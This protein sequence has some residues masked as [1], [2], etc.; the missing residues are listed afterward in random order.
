MRTPHTSSE[1]LVRWIVDA[2]GES[3]GDERDRL[4]YYEAHSA[5]TTA[6]IYGTPICMAACV[7]IFGKNSIGPTLFMGAIPLV[8]S[9]LV[10]PFLSAQ[11]VD[12]WGNYAR[13]SAARKITYFV[14]WFVV[15]PLALFWVGRGGEHFS[16]SHLLPA[17]AGGLVGGVASIVGVRRYQ[18]RYSAGLEGDE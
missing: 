5:M 11:K 12:I 8:L 4:R 10:L 15:L 18:A 14:A 6:L 1:Q 17:V 3:Y 16:S 9:I 13:M 2:D 7:L